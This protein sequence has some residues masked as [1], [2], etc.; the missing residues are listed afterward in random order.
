MKVCELNYFGYV[1]ACF[2]I[3][4][5]RKDVTPTWHSLE[6]KLDLGKIPYPTNVGALIIRQES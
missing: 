5:L 2:L 1:R 4:R 3:E 6:A